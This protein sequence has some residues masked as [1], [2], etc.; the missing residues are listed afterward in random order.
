MQNEGCQ[1]RNNYDNSV[2][3]GPIALKLHMHESIHLAMYFHV[4]QLGCY[5]TYAR[6]TRVVP[7]SRER[8]NRLRSNLV[9]RWGPVSRVVCKSQLGPTLHVRTCRL[10]V[11]DLK[12][13]W[14]DWVQIWY[15]DRD[16]LAVC[17]AIQLNRTHAVLHVQGS[18]SRSLVCRPKKGV[19]LVIL[20]CHVSV[21]HFISFNNEFQ[22]RMVWHH[23]CF[24]T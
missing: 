19:L 13:G 15:T 1:F 9:Q 4:S 10:T 6:A 2:I 20:L 8:L 3:T 7:R 24:K 14:A 22:A 12:N 5:C 21:D 23:I 18:T 11:P 17:R 16:R